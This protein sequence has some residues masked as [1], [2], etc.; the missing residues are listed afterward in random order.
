VLVTAL[1]QSVVATAVSPHFASLKSAGDQ[2]QLQRLLTVSALG[3]TLSTIALGL[4]VALL[5]SDLM[6]FVYGGEFRAS[7]APFV[8]AWLAMIVSAAFGPVQ[9]YANMSGHQNLVTAGFLLS[10]V[11]NIAVSAIAIPRLGAPGAAIGLLAGMGLANAWLWQKIKSRD[12][13]DS[14][15]FSRGALVH[16]KRF[17]IGKLPNTDER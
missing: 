11:T 15:I 17:R 5:G 9:S 8:I 10:V 6:T 4:P 3:M 16:I 2:H 1:G 12:G 14:S 7:Y 13:L